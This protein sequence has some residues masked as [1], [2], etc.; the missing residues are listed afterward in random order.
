MKGRLFVMLVAAVVSASCTCASDH[1]LDFGSTPVSTISWDSYRYG[2]TTDGQMI[3]WN[4]SFADVADTPD[5]LPGEE[6]PL[7]ISK[8][9]QLAEREVPK[10][11][12]LPAA[13]RLDQVEWMH[14]GSHMNEAQ[15]WIYLITFEREYTYQGRHFD[16][17]GTLRIPVLLDGRVIRGRKESQ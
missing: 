16:A 8:A 13:Y 4:V 3:W 11:T 17:R 1:V 2:A 15:K 14:I 7:P 10:Y 5:W 6:P 12:D 9:I